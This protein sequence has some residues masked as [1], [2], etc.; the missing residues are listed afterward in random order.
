MKNP[1]F[2]LMVGQIVRTTSGGIGIIM[3]RNDGTMAIAYTNKD[4]WCSRAELKSS[5]DYKR[6]D[7]IEVYNYNGGPISDTVCNNNNLI[8]K[9]TPYIKSEKEIALEQL[10]AKYIEM[11]KQIQELKE[12][13]ND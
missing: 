3:T 12:T 9:Y 6:G 11:G 10:E 13:I 1:N 5:E 8:W 2:N 4:K 7:I